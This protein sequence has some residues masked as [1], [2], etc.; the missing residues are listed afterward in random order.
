[1]S[2]NKNWFVLFVMQGKEFYIKD[3]LLQL[4]E[5]KKIDDVLLPT[6]KEISEVR[7]K[8]IVRN[9]PV[10]PSYLFIH[11]CLTSDIKSAILETNFVV[12]FLGVNHP[13]PIKDE[14]MDIVRAIAGNCKI[15]SAFK[16]K[17][18]DMIEILGGHC[19]GLSGRVV[20]ILNVNNLKIEIQ[21]FNRAIY[22]DLRIEDVKVA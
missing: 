12:K 21:I 10:Y 7:R 17:I 5:D 3:K 9:L 4:V 13:R 2:K 16:F 20:D 8:K 15:N 14:E 18:G 1:M 11:A 6:I 22:T 19:K